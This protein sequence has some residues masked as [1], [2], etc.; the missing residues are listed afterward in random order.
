MEINLDIDFPTMESL[1]NFHE[2][3]GIQS[4]SSEVSG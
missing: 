4:Q 3:T 1:E 2:S